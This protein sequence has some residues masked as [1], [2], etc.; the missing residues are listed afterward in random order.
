MDTSV[1]VV[2]GHV[3]VEGITEPWDCMGAPGFAPLSDAG[4]LSLCCSIGNSL[5]AAQ[6]LLWEGKAEGRRLKDLP[7]TASS[8]LLRWEWIPR[9][10]FHSLNLAARLY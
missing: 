5:G 7:A 8:Q 1:L 10:G 2:S 6:P 9:S 3:H 4:T